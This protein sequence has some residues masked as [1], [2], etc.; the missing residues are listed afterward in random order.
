MVIL[1]SRIGLYLLPLLTAVGCMSG[2]HLRSASVHSLAIAVYADPN[3]DPAIITRYQRA[4]DDVIRDYA[5]PLRLSRADSASSH[6]L[7]IHLGKTRIAGNKERALSYV[8]TT[9]SLA[10]AILLIKIESPVFVGYISYPSNFGRL[11][12]ELSDT[13][14]TK[15]RRLKEKITSFSFTGNREAQLR[16]QENQLRKKLNKVIRQFEKHNRSLPSFT[17]VQE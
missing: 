3:A 17:R 5:G 1:R 4:I 12:F 2:F 6:V 15:D 10:L 9:T 16:K 11:Q 8:I 14:E 13:L 7:T